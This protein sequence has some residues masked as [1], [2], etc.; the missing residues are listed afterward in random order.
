MQKKLVNLNCGANEY[1]F[2]M[3]VISDQTWEDMAH[4]IV[5]AKGNY[6]K[7]LELTGFKIV[8]RDNKAKF[9]VFFQ[10]GSYH[11]H[12]YHL[13]IFGRASRKYSDVV[14]EL[15]QKVMTHYYGEEYSVALSNKL[16]EL[17]AGIEQ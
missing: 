12:E 13:D 5:L 10:D 1:K 11:E 14:S 15:M 9:K 17:N 3:S 16:A 4:N 7:N 2:D 6:V 8:I